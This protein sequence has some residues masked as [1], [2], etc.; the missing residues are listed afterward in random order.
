M[1]TTVTTKV[2]TKL[3]SK[4]SRTMKTLAVGFASAIT[5]FA[6]AIASAAPGAGMAP[7]AQAARADI[8]KTL[9]FV[10]QFITKFPDA[11]LPGI[12]EELKTLQLNPNTVLPGKQKEL[13]GLAVSAQVPCRY[14]IVAHTEFAKLN[15]ATD[16]EVGEAVAMAAITRHW[17]TYLN[18]IQTDEAKFR[19]EVQTIVAG[20]QKAAKAAAANPNTPAPKPIAVVDG[21]SALRDIAQSIGSTPEF[22]KRF[23]DVARAG[24]WRE[25]K[26]LQ[27]N[28]NTAVSGKDK[29]LI[30][31]AVSAQVPCKFCVIAHT[32]FAKLNG[33]SDAEINETLAMAALTRNMSTMLNG[34][35]VDEAQ[36]TRDVA[37]LVKGAKA[38]AAKKPT[39][40]QAR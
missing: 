6:G 32:E 39:T 21:A 22:L 30:G 40:A 23:P 17:S 3:N 33:A 28:P 38:A 1:K 31:L 37:R 26:E 27:L 8:Q 19:A 18:G 5:L 36:F 25:M 16:A 29:E 34:L 35:Q 13:V 4:I 24:A 20:A 14:C 15:G 12:W 7:A 11:A 10:P 9:G 2:A